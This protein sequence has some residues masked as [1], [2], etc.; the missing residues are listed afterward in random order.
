MLPRFQE[1]R[2]TA[3]AELHDILQARG[4]PCHVNLASVHYFATKQLQ[5]VATADDRHGMVHQG[6]NES[7]QTWRI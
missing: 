7:I 3:I 6:Q 5:L 2:W 1:T 4:D